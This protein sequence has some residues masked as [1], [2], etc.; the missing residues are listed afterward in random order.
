MTHT[1][2][3]LI[4]GGNSDIGKAYAALAAQKGYNIQLAGRNIDDLNRVAADL[5]VR[6]QAQVSAHLF[7]ARDY[8]SHEAF[9][10]SIPQFPD[11]VLCVFGFLGNQ[12]TA[13]NDAKE[14]SEILETNFNGAVS[15]LSRFANE[16][17]KKKAGCIIGVSSVAAERGRMSNYF[18]GS[19]KAGFTAFLSGLRNRLYHNNVHVLTIKPGFVNTRMTEGLPLPKA[20][21]ASPEQVAKAIFIGAK[22]KKNVVY[23]LSIWQLI[24]FIIKMIPEGIFKKL[25]L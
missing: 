11:E 18:Y 1:K 24:M 13:Q 5:K 17:E 15:I 4:L 6:F 3:L 20:L 8:A 2:T 19:A 7:D 25:K 9:I 10:L 16:M 23:S 14:A 12:I 21:T 22:K